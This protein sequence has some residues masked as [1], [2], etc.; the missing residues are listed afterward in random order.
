MA[1]NADEREPLLSNKNEQES[2][3]PDYSPYPS[4]KHSIDCL[5]IPRLVL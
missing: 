3:P 2:P 4:G 5:I 1:T